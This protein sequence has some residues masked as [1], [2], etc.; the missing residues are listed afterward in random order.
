[1]AFFPAGSSSLW[2][3][4]SEV[5]KLAVCRHTLP[6]PL[7]LALRAWRKLLTII[8]GQSGALQPANG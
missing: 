4:P 5:R 3:V 2:R 6:Q 7:G 8:T 1:M